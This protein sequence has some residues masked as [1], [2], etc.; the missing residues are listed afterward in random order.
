MPA[1]MDSVGERLHYQS[2]AQETISRDEYNRPISTGVGSCLKAK[3]LV[4]QVLYIVT[5]QGV[6]L[7]VKG[8]LAWTAITP[9][10]I[11]SLR[12]YTRL[13]RAP[14]ICEAPRR[15]LSSGSA[16]R[17]FGTRSFRFIWSR[18]SPPMTCREYERLSIAL[19]RQ[20]QG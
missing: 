6:P 5:T 8:A 12:C 15:I 13:A 14:E 3:R 19:C 17:N 10:S 20:K 11:P 1:P 18:G 16:M 9:L 4:E 7:R 2:A